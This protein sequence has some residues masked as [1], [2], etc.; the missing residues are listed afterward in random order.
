MDNA[1]TGESNRFAFPAQRAP[2]FGGRGRGT[3][4]EYGPE[5]RTEPFRFPR[6]AVGCDG[7]ARYSADVR[8]KRHEASAVTPGRTRGGNAQICALCPRRSGRGRFIFLIDKGGAPM[9]PVRIEYFGHACFRL[10][11][12]GQRIVVDPYTDGSVAGFPPLHPEAEFVYCSHE[13]GDHNAAGQ[14]PL[15]DGGAAKFRVTELLTDHD[16]AGGSKRGKNTIRIFDF[17]GIR[18]AHFGDLGRDLTEAEEAALKG[19]DCALIPVGG[20]FTIDAV[21]AADIVRRIAP[22]TVIPMHF[23]T[24]EAG[25][26]MLASLEE[27]LKAFDP[28][29]KIVTPGY[30]EATLI[31]EPERLEERGARYHARGLNCC[32]SVL[33]ALREQ[34]GLDMD[35]ATAVGFGFGGGMHCGSVCGALTGALMS[36]GCACERG[37]VDAGA[38]KPRAGELAKA[39]EAAFTAEWGTMLCSDI[40]AKYEHTMCNKCIASAAEAAEKIIVEN[41]K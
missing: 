25:L 1:M 41:R 2:G 30:G 11:R 13:H 9:E 36:I 31:G 35:T 8:K 37:V 26:P 38:E 16:D 23:R 22:A 4:G 34:N 14:I 40:L 20:F 7:C 10:S 24:A 18:V 17:D 15:R 33:L 12:A 6:E 27:A 21:L 5:R 29:Q 3:N 19:L 39:M 28:A 32:Q